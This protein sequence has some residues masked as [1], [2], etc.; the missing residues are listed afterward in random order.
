MIY[1]HKRKW[2]FCDIFKQRSRD[3]NSEEEVDELFKSLTNLKID[4]ATD[5]EIYHSLT[6]RSL[7]SVI[8]L[9]EY[10]DQKANRILTASAFLSALAGVIFSTLVP[11]YEN[12][13][14]LLTQHWNFPVWCYYISFS[15]YIVCLLLGSFLVIYALAPRFKNPLAWN[16]NVPGS[17][18]GSLLFFEKL[19]ENRPK[20]WIE[21]YSKKTFIELQTKYIKGNI[22]ESYIISQK[23]R[24]KLAYL[25]PGISLLNTAVLILIFW[26]ACCMFLINSSPV[27][28][29]SYSPQKEEMGDANKK[30]TEA[31]IQ[32]EL[33]AQ[34]KDDFIRFNNMA[35]I[36]AIRAETAS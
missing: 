22:A 3:K 13:T 10:E 34:E 14:I 16:E 24:D 5:L 2:K 6:S 29:N 12:G 19:L 7:D 9:T 31:L 33:S 25:Q 15:L 4:T 32:G 27:I 26:F 17:E 23:I 28:G 36:A 8:H 11:K 1:F 30:S 20:T 35:T 18:P 21:F